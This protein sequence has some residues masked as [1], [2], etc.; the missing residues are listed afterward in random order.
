MKNKLNR[1]SVWLAAIALISF[2]A[3]GDDDAAEPTKFELKS[4]MA[5]TV[6]LNTTTAVTDVPTDAAIKATFSTNVDATSATNTTVTLTKQGET[7]SVP[8]AIAVSGS[9]VTLTPNAAL[10]AG[11]AY[12]LTLGSIKSSDG[13]TLAT[14]T[15]NF[16]TAGTAPLVGTLAHWSFDGNTNAIVGNFN[17]AASI[18]ITYGPDRKNQ[19]NKAAVFNGSTSIIEIANGSQLLNANNFT[20]S[21]WMK[22]NSDN[23]DRDHFVMG[24]GAFQGLGIEVPKSY[25]SIKIAA[26]YE[27]ADGSTGANDFSFNGDGKTGTNGGWAAIETEKDLTNA[28]GLSALIKDKWAHITFVVNGAT[29]SRFLYVNG[30]LMEKDNFTLLPDGEKLKTMKGLKFSGSTEVEDKLAFGF[31]QSRGGTMWATEPWGGYSFPTA[32][33]FKGSLD[34]IRIFHTAL[35]GAEVQA[36]YNSEK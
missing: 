25:N 1:W 27:W 18:D 5:G 12:T 9:E 10:T 29:K 28:G 3:C 20:L 31:N 14:K 23:G 15:K 4:L 30:E 33:H 35:T 34:E 36:M 26:Q 17:P 2:T 22:L 32:N 6:D 11:T 13:Q 7:T 19:A 8:A 24:L 16:T 21:F